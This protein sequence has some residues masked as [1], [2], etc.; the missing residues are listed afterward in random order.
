MEIVQ[1]TTDSSRV[2]GSVKGNIL[3]APSY[4]EMLVEDNVAGVFDDIEESA[5]LD[6]YSQGI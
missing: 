3:N 4:K 6:S 1:G 2:E 5:G